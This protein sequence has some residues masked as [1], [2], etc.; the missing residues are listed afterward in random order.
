MIKVSDLIYWEI[1]HEEKIKFVSRR[2]AAKC[3]YVPTWVSRQL[4]LLLTYTIFHFEVERTWHGLLVSRHYP[5]WGSPLCVVTF[6]FFCGFSNVTIVV[7]RKTPEEPRKNSSIR[8]KQRNLSMFKWCRYLYT[9]PLPRHIEVICTRPPLG[10]CKL[11][12]LLLPSIEL[13]FHSGGRQT[14]FVFLLAARRTR[15]PSYP[16]CLSNVYTRWVRYVGNVNLALVF[17][18]SYICLLSQ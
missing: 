17:V 4:L 7:I 13:N 5:Y 12:A 15:L 1:F 10:M 3:K 8:K 9:G 6:S 18:S 11:L 2:V 14:M 16:S